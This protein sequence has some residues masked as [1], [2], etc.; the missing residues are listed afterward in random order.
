MKIK[1]DENLPERIVAGLTALGHDTDTIRILGSLTRG[2]IHLGPMK[3]FWC[4]DSRT[5]AAAPR[6]SG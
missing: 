5:T 6:R 1:L 2:S 4:S 3:A